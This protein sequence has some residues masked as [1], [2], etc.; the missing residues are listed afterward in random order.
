VVASGLSGFDVD[1]SGLISVSFFVLDALGTT[2]ASTGQ[3]PEKDAV[4]Q[5]GLQCPTINFDLIL[6]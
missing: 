4:R 1:T 2:T 3:S 5:R 6:I